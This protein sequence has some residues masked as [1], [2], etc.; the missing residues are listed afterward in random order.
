MHLCALNKET[1]IEIFF[2]F[3]IKKK[4]KYQVIEDGSVWGDTNAA[5]D[6]DGD[7]KL[8]LVHNSTKRLRSKFNFN[9]PI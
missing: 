3:F 1:L 4:K 6:H 9:V 2:L 8:T 5:A 7:L